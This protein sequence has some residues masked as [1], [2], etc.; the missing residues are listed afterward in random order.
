[1]P[2]V[3]LACVKNAHRSRN[4]GTIEGRL[5][6][7][8]VRDAR[9]ARSTLGARGTLNMQNCFRRSELELTGT[10]NSLTNGRLSSGG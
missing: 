7:C 2:P 8:L 3:N 1:M 9:S 10:R 4:A 5:G 6:H